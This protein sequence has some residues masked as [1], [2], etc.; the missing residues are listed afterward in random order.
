MD[1]ADYVVGYEIKS[2]EA[3]KTARYAILDSVGC[4]LM[5]STSPSAPSLGPVVPGVRVKHGARVIGTDHDL[6]PVTAAHN[7]ATAVRWLDYNDAWLASEWVHPSDVV[8]AIL[9]LAEYLS[10]VRLER[11]LPPLTMRDVVVDHQGVR[12]RR[13]VG[14]GEQSESDR[15]G[16]RAD[17]ARGGRGGVHARAR[18]RSTRGC[19]RRVASIRRR[20]RSAVFP[21]LSEQRHEERV[22]GGDAASR[23]VWIALTTMRGEMGTASCSPRRC[24]GSTTFFTDETT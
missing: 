21:T 23:G 14:A 19:R 12:T 11:T 15:R 9:P 1:I 5:S 2:K 6:D 17:D 18:R 24:G 22:G 20:R 16:P 13:R 3:V 4:A 10:R 7:T 8:G